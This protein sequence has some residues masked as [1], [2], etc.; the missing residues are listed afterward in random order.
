VYRQFENVAIIASR[1]GSLL[2][3]PQYELDLPDKHKGG[4]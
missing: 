2:L 4:T 3:L 1:F